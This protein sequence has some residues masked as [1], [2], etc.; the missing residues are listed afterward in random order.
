MQ[1]NAFFLT[2]ADF[3]KFFDDQVEQ[4]QLE[5]Y[6]HAVNNQGEW[7]QL[8]QIGIFELDQEFDEYYSEFIELGLIVELVVYNQKGQSFI[9][10]KEF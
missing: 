8:H 5:V 3:D 6:A 7:S 2:I 4:E 10:R 1:N 9:F